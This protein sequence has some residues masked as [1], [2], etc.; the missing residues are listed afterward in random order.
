MALDKT[1]EFSDKQAMTATAVSTVVHENS[2]TSK[3][4]WGTTIS[5]QIGGMSF[6]VAITTTLTSTGT[7]AITLATK[8]ADASLS[9][10]ATTLATINIAAAAVAGTKYS[11]ILPAGTERLLHLGA[12]LTESGSITAGNCNVWLGLK[13]ELID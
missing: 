3:D 9:S 7:M 8:A 10:G 11:V 5:N 4:V 13:N 6:N 2:R 12:L 1:L